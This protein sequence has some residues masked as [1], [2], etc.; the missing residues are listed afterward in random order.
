MSDYTVYNSFSWSSNNVDGYLSA[1]EALKNKPGKDYELVSKAKNAWTTVYVW[2]KKKSTKSKAGS[3]KKSTKPAKSSVGQV[4]NTNTEIDDTKARGINIDENDPIIVDG[5][6]LNAKRGIPKESDSDLKLSGNANYDIDNDSEIQTISKYPNYSVDNYIFDRNNWLK[7]LDPFVGKGFFYFKIFFNFDTN[8]GL[9]GNFNI[10]EDINNGNTAI[11]YLNFCSGLNI[12]KTEA[13]NN[14][15]TSLKKFINLLHDISEKTP[16]FFKEVSGLSN[17][18]ASCVDSED[19]KENTITITCSEEST[20]TRLGTLFD[21]Y[22]YA[23]YDT[24]R[25]KE[26]IPSNLRK[27]EMKIMFFHIPL[28]GYHLNKYGINKD[29]LKYEKLPSTY[30]N[31]NSRISDEEISKKMNNVISFK[32]FTFQN[33]EFDVNSLN[34]F[35]DT[36]SNEN[37]FDLG[38][39]QIKIKYDRVFE[40]RYNEFNRIL[41]SQDVFYD[42]NY[43]DNDDNTIND[44][45]L[46]AIANIIETKLSNYKS[47]HNV[48]ENGNLYSN[49]TSVLGN[50]YLNKVKYLKNGTITDG[51]IYEHDFFNSNYFKEKMNRIKNG[52]ISGNIYDYDFGPGTDYWENKLS[53]I[54][55][56]KLNG[57]I[58]DYN[59][60]PG[61]DYWENK[62]SL[63]NDFTP[64]GNL[65]KYDFIRSG[66][67]TSRMNTD[68]FDDKLKILKEG[69]ISGNI[70]DYNLGPGTN[71]WDDKMNLLSDGILSDM[72]DITST[73]IS[74]ERGKRNEFKE[75]TNLSA[76]EEHNQ[77]LVSETKAVENQISFRE[78]NT[79]SL[80]ERLG[81]KN[82]FN[83]TIKKKDNNDNDWSFMVPLKDAK[84]NEFK[85]KSDT[86]YHV[87]PIGL[88]KKKSLKLSWEAQAIKNANNMYSV[89]GNPSTASTMTGK[90]FEGAFNRTKN[91]LGF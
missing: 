74:V 57:N 1:E 30:G 16:W 37:I 34:E 54:K 22:K 19:F 76:K 85:E 12:Y 13:L 61:T 33:C 4:E 51:N 66:S 87:I 89:E 2:E 29:T 24:I 5:L 11:Q 38:K 91:A 31:K 55:D 81:I 72:T 14:R 15:K 75:N 68:Y 60:G 71:Y 47:E 77:H 43:T 80:I 59:L 52:R 65:Y 41:I 27:F 79:A 53:L 88:A 45:R 32:M 90:I 23:C 50:Y 10:P 39:N 58:Y 35:N 69:N 7:Q 46:N 21:L 8:Y 9:L 17:I 86:E 26:I 56:S 28:H 20:D 42:F 70:Y 67:G 73:L 18:K 25:N 40:N 36:I 49:S 63:L 48:Y 82:E 78:N 6:K 84:M 62:L 83:E 44:E 3:T 64:I